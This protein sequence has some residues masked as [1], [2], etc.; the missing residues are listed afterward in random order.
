[1][2]KAG[3]LPHPE[4]IPPFFMLLLLQYPDEFLALRTLQERRQGIHHLL[5]ILERTFAQDQ[6]AFPRPRG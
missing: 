1:M 6:T 5:V 2:K 3:T 4:Q